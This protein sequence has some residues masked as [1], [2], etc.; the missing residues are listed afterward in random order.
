MSLYLISEFGGSID[1]AAIT[2]FIDNGGNV[3]VAGSSAVGTPIRELGSDCGIEFDEEKTSVIDHHNFDASDDGTVRS[4]SFY[5]CQIP[6][7]CSIL[8]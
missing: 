4:K 5:V 8:L 2:N 7:V 6:L 1:V 3:L